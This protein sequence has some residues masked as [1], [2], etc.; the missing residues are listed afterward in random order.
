MDFKLKC[1]IVAFAFLNPYDEVLVDFLS[2]KEAL[3]L[4]RSECFREQQIAEDTSGAGWSHLGIS[5]RRDFMLMNVDMRNKGA[6]LLG[7]FSV[8]KP[9]WLILICAVMWF[10]L[11]LPPTRGVA[12]IV[13]E[14]MSLKGPSPIEWCRTHTV[15]RN[16]VR[17]RQNKGNAPHFFSEI[18]AKPQRR[19]LLVRNAGEAN[20]EEPLTIDNRKRILYM[21]FL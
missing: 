3:V 4:V 6:I 8:A 11:A 15:K 17:L 14:N 12:V 13:P 20:L 18:A 16:K 1:N 10:Q 2:H 19:H 5:E 21:A 7:A 9:G